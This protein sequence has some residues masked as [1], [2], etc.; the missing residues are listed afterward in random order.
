[1]I[2]V[3]TARAT[4]L[5]A[6]FDAYADMYAKGYAN[7]V[8][9]F[10]NSNWKELLE[11]DPGRAQLI[12]ELISGE[13]LCELLPTLVNVYRARVTE[14]SVFDRI[15]PQE[16]SVEDIWSLLKAGI[17]MSSTADRYCN[18]SNY[19]LF[20]QA[21]L[22]TEWFLKDTTKAVIAR[23][24]IFYTE[25]LVELLL[26]RCSAMR[27]KEF[28][29]LFL[30]AK[31]KTGKRW[32]AENFFSMKPLKKAGM[33]DKD[34]VDLIIGGDAYEA[35]EV[36]RRPDL[37][38][39][40]DL[41]VDVKD[42]LKEFF[43]G[44][45]RVGEEPIFSTL[46]EVCLSYGISIDDAMTSVPPSRY[47]SEAQDYHTFCEHLTKLSLRCGAITTP[48]ISKYL[49]SGLGYPEDGDD[50]TVSILNVYMGLMKFMGPHIET[51]ID[52]D[53]VAEIYC[54]TATRFFDDPE[55]VEDVIDEATKF[56][57]QFKLGELSA[58]RISLSL[59]S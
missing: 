24:E 58:K 2:G 5:Q 16:L 27:R 43:K 11:S 22:K 4:A 33:S 37:F 41:D 59:N 29:S 40:L 13:T 1:M 18:D 48:K 19:E 32:A 6:E 51:Y 46:T 20:I 10:V 12:A 34:I 28:F 55:V 54:R 17:S 21:H 44:E 36:F 38:R 49:V 42:Y 25:S 8:N 35:Y 15:D 23:A 57:Q 39:K 30:K 7:A 56:F 50:D 9:D 47:L 52:V 45:Y 3:T 53:R 26:Q 14:D 31:K